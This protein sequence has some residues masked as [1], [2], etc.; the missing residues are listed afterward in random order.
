MNTRRKLRIDELINFDI[1]QKCFVIGTDEAG[2]GPVSGPV[3][4]SAVFFPELT[5]KVM[6]SIKFIDDSKKF[7]SNPALRK[8]MADQIKNIAIYSIAECSVEEI[9]KYNILQASLYAMKTMKKACQDVCLQMDKNT[10]K[11]N[12]KRFEKLI[13][14]D[15][16]FIIPDYKIK[17]KAIKKGDS[18]SASIAAASILAKV[19][20]DELM[21]KLSREFP[22]Y[23]WY[24]N[25]GYATAFHIEAI[26]KHGCCKWH[27]KSFL[28]KIFAEQKK[29]F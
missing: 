18:L 6:E 5:D 11:I 8:D 29:L 22:V 20:R 12:T 19:Y 16:N 17:Q 21:E 2:R 28:G 10:D 4:A 26:R 23:G 7:S 25:K 14:V 1:S 24:K 27:R 9:E 13:L 3:V 15:G